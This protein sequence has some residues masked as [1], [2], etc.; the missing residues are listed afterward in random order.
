[1]CSQPR[2][3]RC[4]R[5]SSGMV[6]PR[7]RRAR[8]ACS[9]GAGGAQGRIRFPER[10]A[11]HDDSERQ[12][13]RRHARRVRGFERDILRDRVRAGIAQARKNGRPHGRLPT[14]AHQLRRSGGSSSGVSASARSP[15]ACA[16]AEP[17][18]EGCWEAERYRGRIEHECC[19]RGHV[20]TIA[21]GIR[22]AR[23]RLR[24]F[25]VR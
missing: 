25:L 2:G 5:S 12:S 3:D 4:W 17:P 23:H 8:I 9:R 13:A 14:V 18:S 19:R 16:S 22:S 10:S 15:S 7:F 6:W 24:T 21:C 11:R 20:L 1:M